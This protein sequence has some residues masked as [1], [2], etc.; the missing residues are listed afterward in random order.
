MP[1]VYDLQMELD[2]Q[3]HPESQSY[4]VSGRYYEA[5]GFSTSTETFRGMYRRREKA[6]G[7]QRG[8]PVWGRAALFTF[9][10]TLLL[11][12]VLVATNALPGGTWVAALAAVLI[13]STVLAVV[14]LARG[15][16][17]APA[18][19]TLSLAVAAPLAI[20]VGFAVFFGFFYAG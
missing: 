18:I 9:I 17:R 7:K 14:S 2:V 16:R 8:A 20:V 5:N 3:L 10:G 6:Q 15:E 1:L 12:Y 4:T 11:V 19:W 13:V